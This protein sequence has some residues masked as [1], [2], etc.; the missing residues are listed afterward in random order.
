MIRYVKSFMT[1]YIILFEIF[2][3][4]VRSNIYVY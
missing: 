3:K 2:Y 1:L 4:D